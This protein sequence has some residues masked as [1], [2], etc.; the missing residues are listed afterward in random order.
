MHSTGTWH[1]GC[2][3]VGGAW[4]LLQPRAWAPLTSLTAFLSIRVSSAWAQD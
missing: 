2:R 4:G 3:S 1:C